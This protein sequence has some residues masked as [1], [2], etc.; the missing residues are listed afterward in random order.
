MSFEPEQAAPRVPIIRA[1]KLFWLP[2]LLGLVAGLYILG[3]PHLLWDFTYQGDYDHRHYVRCQ[4]VGRYTQ[5]VAPSDG[6]C[7]YIR[8]FKQEED[9]G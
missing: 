5:V 6:Q 2:V 7:P 1:G 8:F 4:Y 3:W 9:H